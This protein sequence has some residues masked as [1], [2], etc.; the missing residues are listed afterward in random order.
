MLRDLNFVNVE[1]HDRLIAVGLRTPS[2]RLPVLAAMARIRERAASPVRWAS[3][4]H[5]FAAI[6]D[7]EGF[8]PPVADQQGVFLR[9]ACLP[10]DVGCRD[11][12]TSTH[13][14]PGQRLVP[15]HG[16]VVQRR[17]P[18]IVDR[19]YVGASIYEQPG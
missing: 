15:V 19:R 9:G 13:E 12:G 4:G 7:S 18:E 5:R 10:E 17:Q 3:P 6:D 2:S 8:R 11:V 14:K 16:R 1:K